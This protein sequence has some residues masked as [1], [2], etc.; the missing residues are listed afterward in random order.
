VAH[1]SRI[2]TPQ[3]LPLQKKLYI[4]TCK[5]RYSSKCRIRTCNVGHCFAWQG[6]SSNTLYRKRRECE[7]IAYMSVRRDIC[8][9]LLE[10]LCARTIHHRL[11]QYVG[12]WGEGTARK[13][14]LRLFGSRS[15]DSDQNSRCKPL[16]NT[17][18]CGQRQ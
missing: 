15:G 17:S 11:P 18:V 12:C 14:S 3:P 6:T 7:F 2:S 10:C 16:R 13:S 1:L 5:A 4:S 8:A 9:C